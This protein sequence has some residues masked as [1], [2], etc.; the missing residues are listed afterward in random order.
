MQTQEIKILLQRY[1]NSETTLEEERRLEEYFSGKDVAEELAEYSG[2]FGGIANLSKTKGTIDIEEEVMDFILENE[3]REKTRFR[4]MWI[5]VTGVAASIIIVL[6]TFLF[7]QEQQKP[8]ADTYQNPDQAYEVASQTLQF[9]GA[10]YNKGLAELSNF[11]KLQ[12][13]QHT[14]SKGVQPIN[15]FYFGIDKLKQENKQ[16]STN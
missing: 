16:E 10:K 11:E 2:Y 3:N 13:A 15:N 5:T 1:F 12:R 9:I 7:Y 6:G 4:K 8:F 14:M